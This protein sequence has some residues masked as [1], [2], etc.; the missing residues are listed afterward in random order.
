M[1]VRKGYEIPES[2]SVEEAIGTDDE[3]LRE[4]MAERLLQDEEAVKSEIEAEKKELKRFEAELE[5]NVIEYERDDNDRE[6]V[7]RA[8]EK[9]L[10]ILHRMAG[11]FHPLSDE[12]KKALQDAVACRK[13]FEGLIGPMLTTITKNNLN[14]FQSVL[15]QDLGEDVA[16]QRRSAFGAIRTDNG[17]TY[18]VG[19]I[20]Y[21]T[22]R[23]PTYEE[24]VL[25]IEWLYVHEKFRKRGV[26]R[27]L[28]GE[29]LH[30]MIRAGLPAV[31]CEFPAKGAYNQLLA[32]ILGSWSFEF[33]TW[34]SPEALIRIGDITGFSQI[35]A[36]KK[37]VQSWSSLDGKIQ[38]LLKAKAYRKFGCQ[39]WFAKIS[40]DY[41][42][43]ETS[44]YLG[45]PGD[46][47][48]LLLSHKTPS[49]L[50]RLEY[51]GFLKGQEENGK[52]LISR[53]LENAAKANEEDTLILVPV[54][55]EEIGIFL[56]EICPG[57]LGQYMVEGVLEV[58][59]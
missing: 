37:G 2:L 31:S 52:R 55:Q 16:C 33:D 56:Q 7:E 22:D 3:A 27:F 6:P 5:Q 53:F 24:G 17:R 58:E 4:K 21:F 26:A 39:H 46:V 30:Q 49:G 9:K 54:E 38:E 42:D 28:L 36:M 25:R 50:L 34:I 14:L 19:A 23:I 11:Q 18:G 44:C 51:L 57:Q 8:Y 29:L 43:R 48:A 12:G 1:S 15:P 10:G 32:Y 59:K 41:I 35:S 20:V 40:P 45:S 47:K 13:E